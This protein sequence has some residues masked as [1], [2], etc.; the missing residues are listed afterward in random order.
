MKKI[1]LLCMIFSFVLSG[2]N[3]QRLKEQHAKFE[4]KYNQL[5]GKTY[6][7][8]IRREGVPTGEAKLSDGSRVVE[9][10]NSQTSISG[11]G[12]YPVPISTYIPNL[13][14]TGGVWVYGEME[15]SNPVLSRTYYCK[16]DFIVSAQSIIQSWKAEGNHCY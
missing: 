8:L 10:L 13:S 15:R 6:D 9:Y 1:I 11:G 12:S 5:I 2:C 16:L 3:T 14:G 4:E 7:D